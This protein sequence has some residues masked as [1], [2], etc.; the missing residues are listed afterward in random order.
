MVCGAIAL[1][2]TSCSSSS[3]P[4][5]RCGDGECSGNETASTCPSDCT[6]PPP[7]CGD[8]RCEWDRGEN[9]NNC[10]IDCGDP[11]LTIAPGT[12]GNVVHTYCGDRLALPASGVVLP[13]TRLSQLCT[14]HCWSTALAMLSHYYKLPV[15]ECGLAS[16][17]AGFIEPVCC[18]HGACSTPACDKPAAPDKIDEVIESLGVYAARRNAPITG[19][20]LANEIANGRPVL[21]GYDDSFAGHLVLV[22][23][24]SGSWEDPRY[25]V[26]DPFYGEFSVSYAELRDGYVR[27]ATPWSWSTTWYHLSPS[28]DGCNTNFDPT[29]GCE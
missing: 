11:P 2:V 5:P 27:G 26:L 19:A 7:R 10:S 23:G 15:S 12:N 16:A 1:L 20:T 29:C 9:R 8:G 18:L 4:S 14:E 24:V 21:I 3:P 6:A 13:I 17:N 22:R 25:D 28:P